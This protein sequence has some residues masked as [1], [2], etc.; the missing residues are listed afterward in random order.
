MYHW[1]SAF[2][3]NGDLDRE[4]DL[5][6]ESHIT[7]ICKF[8]TMDHEAIQ[9]NAKYRSQAPWTPAQRELQK[10]NVYK[11]PG[12]K[13]DCIVRSCKTIM[14]KHSLHFFQLFQHFFLIDLVERKIDLITINGKEVGADDFFPV[15]V[16][17]ILQSNPRCLL[18]TV[19]YIRYFYESK[20]AGEAS[21]WWSQFVVAVEFIK[22]LN[23]KGPA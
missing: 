17:V 20:A 15:L 1:N 18:T 21:Y 8:I 11:S 13:L 4:K 7:E 14:S 12:D 2:F 3:P 6:F 16:F 9:I 23:P 5:L 19:Q 10:I 22:T